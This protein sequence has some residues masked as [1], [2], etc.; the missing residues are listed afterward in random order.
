MARTSHGS[1]KTIALMALKNLNRQKK[2]SVLLGGAIAFGVLIIMVIDGFAGAFMQNVSENVA[3]IAAGHIFVAGSEL[4]DSG[5][6][7]SVIRDDSILTQVLKET[8]IPALYVSKRSRARGTLIFESKQTQISIQGVDFSSERY[9]TSRLYLSQGSFAAMS[10]HQGLILSEQTARKLN[11]QMGD[12]LLLQLTTV[13]GQQN[14]GD[15]VLV[16]TTPDTG[17]LSDF[18]A[19]AN[20]SYVNELLNL[21][22][23][24]YQSLG[25]YLPSLSGMDRYADA[26]YAD[27]KTKANVKERTKSSATPGFSMGGMGGFF[28]AGTSEGTWTGVRYSVTTLDDMLSSVKQIVSVLNSV[29]VGVL[30][31]LFVIIMVGILNTFRMT[32]FERIR[33]IGTMRAIGTQRPQVRNLFLLEALFLAIGGMIVGIAVAAIV[34]GI[35]SLFNLGVTSPLFMILRKGHFSFKVPLAQ[36]LMNVII[37]AALTLAAAYLPARSAARLEPAQALRTTK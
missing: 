8:H 26:F 1:A 22:T 11:A 17:M 23:G 34:M 5:K 32:M 19:Y 33:E 15:M 12:R 7:I 21:G 14:V 31:V 9:L 35:L 3:D 28:G 30:I 16:A 10:N 37:I 20:L 6:T 24:E 25:I 18:S 27:L 4:S 13:T 29:S 2:R 36:G